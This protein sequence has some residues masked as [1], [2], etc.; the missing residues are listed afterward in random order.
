[1]RICSSFLENNASGAIQKKKKK[2]GALYSY[3]AKFNFQYCNPHSC[4]YSQ[5]GIWMNRFDGFWLMEKL[6][7]LEM[8]YDE[9]RE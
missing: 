3:D 4:L 1:M 6:K 2:R 7:G 5:S 9:W 8:L